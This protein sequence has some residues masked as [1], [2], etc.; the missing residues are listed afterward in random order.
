MD[1][2]HVLLVREWDHQMSSSGCCGRIEGDLTKI[3][4]EKVFPERRQMMEEMGAV[5]RALYQAFPD[6]VKVEVVDPRNLIAYTTVMLQQQ[7]RR[8]L[9][10]RHRLQQFA[11]GFD[12][13]AIFID[14][15]LLCAGEIPPPE[16]VVASVKDIRQN[17]VCAIR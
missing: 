16:Q 1:K 9:G 13:C 8:Q 15:E 10:W 14:G 5:Y 11:R 6:E 3:Q 2:T 17:R 4:G 7:Q 12:R